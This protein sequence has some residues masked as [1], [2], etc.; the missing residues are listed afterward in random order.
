MVPREVSLH[1]V[2]AELEQAEPIV[3]VF[4]LVVDSSML[5]E[6]DL[7]IRVTGGS[8]VDEEKYVL[9]MRFDGYRAIPPLVEFVHPET[10]ELGVRPAYPS[11]FHRHPC[12]C[13]RYNR[14]T[15]QEHANLH[16]D[17]PYG[18]WSSEPGTERVGGMLN[19]IFA[20]INDHFDSYKGRMG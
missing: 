16:S 11:C 9:E 1:H 2:Q 14:K 10:G 18:D 7:R 19:H 3:K 8:R 5:S 12:I 17:W 20:S 6:E 15:Y 13:T 4:R